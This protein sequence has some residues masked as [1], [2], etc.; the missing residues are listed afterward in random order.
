VKL[1]RLLDDLK[2]NLFYSVLYTTGYALVE[3][4]EALPYK[5]EGGGFESRWCN[6]EFFHS[7]N[8]V[9]N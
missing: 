5:M 8:A 6:L 4:V 3:L 2:R 9:F 1:V 7:H